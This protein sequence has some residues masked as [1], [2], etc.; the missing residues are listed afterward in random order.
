MDARKNR[1]HSSENFHLDHDM[2]SCLTAFLRSSRSPSCQE[3][4]GQAQSTPNPPVSMEAEELRMH[5]EVIERVLNDENG[6]L[7]KQAKYLVAEM[8]KS[9]RREKALKEEV[10]FAEAQCGKMQQKLA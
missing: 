4:K 6:N 8:R 10:A 1:Y 7:K 3:V 5:Y 9:L 2:P